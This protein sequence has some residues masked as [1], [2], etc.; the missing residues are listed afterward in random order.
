LAKGVRAAKFDNEENPTKL[1]VGLYCS[2]IYEFLDFKKD[3]GKYGSVRKLM[4]GHYT[5]A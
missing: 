1:T 3:T 2:E 5:P 4:T